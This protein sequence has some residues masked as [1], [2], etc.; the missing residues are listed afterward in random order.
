[1][2]AAAPSPRIL[3]V[4]DD[5]GLL[6]LMA[7]ALRAEGWEIVTAGSG[8]AALKWLDE[9]TPDLMLL[10][11]KMQDVGGTALLHQLQDRDVKVPFLVVTG[12][13]D[14]KV[15]VEVMKQGALEYVM[16][17][18]TMLER[19]PAMVK[20]A[21]AVLAQEKALRE[22]QAEQRRLE[23][24]ILAASERE[25][26]SIGADLHDGLGQQLTALEFMCTALKDDAVRDH[27][28]LAPRLDHMSR[29]LREAV[30]Q[31]RLLA[32]G[33][34]PVGVEPDALFLGLTELVERVNYLNRVRVVFEC[35]QPVV[36]P[37]RTVAGHLYRIVQ[38]ALNNAL[39]HARAKA[40]TIRLT[41]TAAALV[42]E[43][44]DDGQGLTKPRAGQTGL[45]LGVMRHRANAIGA[46]L[47]VKSRRGE[48]V[49]ITCTL[50]LPP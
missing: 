34:A 36:V 13:G 14:E 8:R 33:L 17:D 19:L 4:D 29:M 41:R 42:L 48:G 39:K 21:L 7:E 31:T 35:P 24:E 18:T 38:E 27:P 28:A 49:I 1:V 45:G 2:P 47:A 26:Q 50:P 44:S 10:D 5:A 3:V 20:R 46:E 25:R 12:R 15:A 23:G 37:D 43:V 11:L 32:R 40:V 9:H 22:A 6:I 30:T 16:K